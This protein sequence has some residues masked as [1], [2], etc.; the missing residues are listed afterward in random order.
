MLFISYSKSYNPSNNE[1]RKWHLGEPT[2][3]LTKNGMVTAIQADGDEL[4]Y[5]R[6]HF[7]NVPMA[8]A[9]VVTWTGEMAMFIVANL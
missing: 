3:D 8:N 7:S 2:E 5:I 1:T 6:G 4:E 9:S